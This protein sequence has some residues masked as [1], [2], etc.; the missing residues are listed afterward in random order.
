MAQILVVD[1]EVGIRDLLSEILADEGHQVLLAESASE[2]RR[3][4]ESHRPDLVLLDIWMPDTDGI[5]LLK[6]WAASGQL[7]MPV[8]MMSGHGTIETAVEATRIGALDYLEKPIALQRLLA[9]VKRALRN[10]EAVVPRELSLATLGRSPALTETRKRLAQLAQAG[11]PLMLRGERGMRPELFARLLAAAGAPFVEGPEMLTEASSVMLTRAA[12]GV[13][14][15]G[16]LSLLGRAEQKNLEFL[17]ARSEKHKARVVSFSPIDARALIDK[18]EFDAGMLARL[19]ELVLK[20]P[21]LR[22]FAE[23]VPDLAALLLVQL[24]ETRACPPRR[25]SVAALNAL[26]HHLWPGNLAELD[27]VVKNLALGALEE[28][29]DLSDVERVLAAHAGSS[30]PE[31]ALDRPYREAREAF[32]RLY[33]EHLLVREN[34]S[35]SKVAEHSG[36][37]RTHLYRKLKALGLPVGRREES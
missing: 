17:L 21:A 14:F 27:S 23:D 20:L 15:V 31:I 4:R 32:E 29:I 16:D 9:T 6:E 22:D 18:H 2:A 19:S 11:A 12:G 5:S 26:R 36:L 25:F 37:E 35:M 30:P 13:L 28:D 7:G 1:D 34:G 24:V 3:L 8:V 33:F 10:H